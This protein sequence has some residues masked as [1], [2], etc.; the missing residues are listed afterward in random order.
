MRY[1]LLA[2]AFV[3]IGSCETRAQAVVC[4]PH[5]PY[6][7]EKPILQRMT[8]QDQWNEFK[9][10]L[11]RDLAASEYRQRAAMH[12]LDYQLRRAQLCNSV[13]QVGC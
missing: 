2:I 10:E 6:C 8:P 9:A 13:T 11:Q 1:L 12:G 7:Y 4:P 3:T 5:L